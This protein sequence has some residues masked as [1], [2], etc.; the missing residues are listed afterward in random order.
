[1]IDKSL[2]Y[3]H[4]TINRPE[5]G[6]KYQ[7]NATVDHC[8]GTN[9]RPRPAK[10]PRMMLNADMSLYLNFIV[11]EDGKPNCNYE[12]CSKNQESFAYVELF[13]QNEVEF[14]KAFGPAFVKMVEHG[15]QANCML[16]DLITDEC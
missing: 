8:V 1:M 14:K 5:F 2:K 4:A 15:Y 11:G 10:N 3:A 7:W 13:A 12:I 6:L 9:C 16:R